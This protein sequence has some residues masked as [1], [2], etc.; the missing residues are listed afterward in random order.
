MQVPNKFDDDYVTAQVSE[1]V[2]YCVLSPTISDVT[3]SSFYT[4]AAAI[5]R[6][7]GDNQN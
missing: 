4:F 1:V 3:F 5:H 7:V 6:N 2:Q